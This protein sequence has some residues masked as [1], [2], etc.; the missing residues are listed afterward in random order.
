MSNPLV[1]IIPAGG[2]KYVYALY[3]LAGIVV[4]ALSVA[5]V[6]VGTAPEVLAFIGTALGL[7]AASNTSTERRPYDESH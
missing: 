6:D 7:V 4:G 1:D 5:G 3:A 2:R